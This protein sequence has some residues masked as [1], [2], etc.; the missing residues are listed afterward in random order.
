MGDPTIAN[1]ALQRPHHVGLPPELAE[2]TRAKAPI[3]RD[4]RFLGAL[5]AIR[6]L[7]D[8]HRASLSAGSDRVAGPRRAAQP[9]AAAWQQSGVQGNTGSYGWFLIVN[10]PA[11]PALEAPPNRLACAF[12]CSIRGS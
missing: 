3:Q 9:G 5:C 8:R 7:V 1:R 4:E 11:L 2:A 12:N 10:D 6:S